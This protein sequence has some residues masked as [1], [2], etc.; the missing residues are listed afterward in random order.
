MSLITYIALKCS[1]KFIPP[2]NGIERRFRRRINWSLISPENIF[3]DA[4]IF[5]LNWHGQSD[6]ILNGWL[7]ISPKSV[8]DTWFCLK[9]PLRISFA[10]KW[11][12]N[13]WFHFIRCQLIIFEVSIDNWFRFKIIV[14]NRFC[15][16]IYLQFYFF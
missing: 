1:Y 2:Q 6:S 4:N 10:L 12:G 16:I 9:I 7:L 8:I 13:K 15:I 3:D 14:W 11:H 5:R